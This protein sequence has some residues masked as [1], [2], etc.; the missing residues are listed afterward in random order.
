MIK[1]IFIIFIIVLFSHAAFSQTDEV[2]ERAGAGIY[3][4]AFRSRRMIFIL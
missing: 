3:V 2:I 4:S 1:N